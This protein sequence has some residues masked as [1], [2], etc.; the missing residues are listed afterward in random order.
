MK[1]WEEL[2]W[3]NAKDNIKDGEKTN[4]NKGRQEGKKER[5]KITQNYKSFVISALVFHP[6]LR[7]VSGLLSTDCTLNT[8]NKHGLFNLSS[9]DKLLYHHSLQLF[10]AATKKLQ[11]KQCTY[12][13]TLRRI[14]TTIIVV[15]KQWVLHNLSVCV[16]V[17]V[18]VFVALIIQHAFR[19]RYTVICGLPP[20]T[21]FFHI[22]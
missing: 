12:N 5:W 7:L 9:Y 10:S 8:E 19:M 15:E 1:K 21:I 16:C 4:I 14:R 18:C 11:D 13:I 2:K 22:I 20:S 6:N 3:I 17:C